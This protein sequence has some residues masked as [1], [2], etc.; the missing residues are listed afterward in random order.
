[1]FVAVRFVVRF[2]AP[3]SVMVTRPGDG[4]PELVVSVILPPM[5]LTAVASFAERMRMTKAS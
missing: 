5:L 3:L 4:K 1:V 2:C